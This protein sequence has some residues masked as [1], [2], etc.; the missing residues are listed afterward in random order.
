MS[1]TAEHEQ[2]KGNLL[3]RNARVLDGTDTPV[4]D[5]FCILIRDGL[6][7]EIAEGIQADGIPQLDVNGACAIPGL[8]ESHM[9]LMWGPGVMLHHQGKPTEEDW[10][11]TWGRNYKQHLK[12]YLACGVT[13]IHDVAAFPFVV[14]EVRKHYAEGGVGPRFL[15]LGPMISPPK[16]YANALEACVSSEQEVEAELDKL[17]ALEVGAVKFLFPK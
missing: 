9:H 17:V 15:A 7:L 2:G 1:Q 4:R 14:H 8:I 16:G 12:A 11:R 10:T 3:I 6:I 13:T 5:G